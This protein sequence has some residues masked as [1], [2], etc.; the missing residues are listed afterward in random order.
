MLERG[1]ADA[2][3][4]NYVVWLS[5]A[6]VRDLAQI[7]AWTSLEED[8]A[9]DFIIPFMGG[10]FFARTMKVSPGISKSYQGDRWVFSLRTF[11]EKGMLKPDHLERMAGM[12]IEDDGTMRLRWLGKTREMQRGLLKESDVQHLKS[13]LQANARP[14]MRKSAVP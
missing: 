5:M 8:G 4:L 11:Y 9:Y 6:V 3:S 12:N 13:W 10:A 7:F 1:I 2:K 14:T